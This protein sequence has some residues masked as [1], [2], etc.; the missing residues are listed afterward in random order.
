MQ[1]HGQRQGTI[2]MTLPTIEEQ[3]QLTPCNDCWIHD[4]SLKKK[5]QVA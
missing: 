4:D 2:Y 5:T 3:K 1:I